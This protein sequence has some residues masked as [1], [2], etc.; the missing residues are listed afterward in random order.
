MMRSTGLS[1]RSAEKKQTESQEKIPT[2]CKNPNIPQ[3]TGYHPC[4]KPT[5]ATVT[6]N[7]TSN[8]FDTGH[9]LALRFAK[10]RELAGNRVQHLD[11]VGQKED[12]LHL[13]VGQVTATADALGSLHMRATQQGHSGPLVH[14][15]GG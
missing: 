5:I 7:L 1:G 14:I 10:E 8:T 15:L 4:N 3:K 12:D 2:L 6:A 9:L 13:M 11:K